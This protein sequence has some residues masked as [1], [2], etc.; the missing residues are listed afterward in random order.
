[1]WRPASYLES[2]RAGVLC[3]EEV[4]EVDEVGEA[5]VAEQE[6]EEA[7]VLPREARHHA[8]R[9]PLHGQRRRYQQQ[10][11]HRRHVAEEVHGVHLLPAR[12]GNVSSG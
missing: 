7:G 11:G 12:D 9:V 2:E 10:H 8:E 5:G 4:G 1:M 3:D 6:P